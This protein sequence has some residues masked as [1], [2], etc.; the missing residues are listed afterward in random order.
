M[1][2]IQQPT[3]SSS[4]LFWMVSTSVSYCC[5]LSVSFLGKFWLVRL[6][7]LIQL[8][9]FLGYVRFLVANILLHK[10]FASVNSSLVQLFFQF[11]LWS[12]NTLEA[13]DFYISD[14]LASGVYC[15]F[16]FWLCLCCHACCVYLTIRAMVI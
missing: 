14:L 2:M 7:F 13:H 9:S 1:E 4:F 16:V 3:G 15:K 12:H 10:A 11:H 6:N 8:H 5:R